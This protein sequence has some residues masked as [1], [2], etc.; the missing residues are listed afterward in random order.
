MIAIRARDAQWLILFAQ[1][2][3][4]NA[5]PPLN[6]FPFRACYFIS[7]MTARPLGG[8]AGPA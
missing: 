4:T 7:K 3:T 8:A 2:S 1:S 6:R 5:L